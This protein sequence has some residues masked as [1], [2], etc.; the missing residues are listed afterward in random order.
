MEQGGLQVTGRRV[1]VYIVLFRERPKTCF[2]F[3][4]ELKTEYSQ[5][6]DLMFPALSTEE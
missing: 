5:V 2:D 3:V 4:D 6:P 1:L